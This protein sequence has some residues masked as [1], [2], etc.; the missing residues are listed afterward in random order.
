MAIQVPRVREG[1][2]ESIEAIKIHMRIGEVMLRTIEAEYNNYP[3]ELQR[4]RSDM[5]TGLIRKINGRLGMEG[6]FKNGCL[7]R[8]KSLPERFR[9]GEGTQ[10]CDHAIP[11][12][13]LANMYLD[14]RSLNLVQLALYP[15]VRLT[16][17]ANK[18]L[19][20]EGL[21]D[22]GHKE[23]LP[24]FRYSGL[25]PEIEIVTHEGTPVDP[26]TWT[27]DNHWALVKKTANQTPELKE[28]IEHF[29]IKLGD[30]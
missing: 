24:L 21:A 9:R 30:D 14:N 5:I 15:V 26:A 25:V 2:P 10:V 27:D 23:G 19:T 18:Q 29:K 7:Y 17:K 16:D 13:V 28:I 4:Q 1:K 8:Q 12:V 22:S 6:N 11:A 20:T 3:K